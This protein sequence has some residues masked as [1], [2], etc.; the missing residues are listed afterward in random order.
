M[1]EN[2]NLKPEKVFY[3]FEEI[4]NIPRG[5]GNTKAVSDYCVNFAKERGLYVRQDELNNVVIKKSATDGNENKPG[6]IIQGHLDMVAEKDSDS[7]HDFMK[8]PIELIVDGDYITANKTTL[9]ADDG[10]AV[11]VALALLDDNTVKHPELEIIFTVDEETGMYGAMGLDMSDINGKYLLNLDSE[12]DGIITVGCAGGKSAAVKYDLELAEVAGLIYE[13]KISGLKGGHSGVEI[14]KERANANILMGRILKY[15]NDR[16]A[17]RLVSINGGAKDNVITKESTARFI[18][19]T[20]EDVEAKAAKMTE[21]LREVAAIIKNEFVISDKDISIN[22]S[23]GEYGIFYSASRKATNDILAFINAVPF[24]PQYRVPGM[25]GLVETSL[26]MGVVNTDKGMLS[27]SMSI[28]SSVKSRKD[29]MA[30]KIEIL[31]GLTGAEFSTG[32]EYPEWSYKADSPL[33]KLLCKVYKKMFNDELK[34][35]V[36]HAGL[37]CGYVLEKKPDLDVVSFGPQMYDIHTTDERVSISSV[38]K[39]YDFVK[40]ILEEICD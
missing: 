7:T 27:I 29:L 23:D 12:D 5:S 8:D 31:A 30:E 36:I 17:I 22:L 1:L 20:H 28:R 6:V 40:G 13:L 15:I 14:H 37:E 2:Y 26:N 4:S 9:G 38:A 25:N 33:Q 21:I 32:G 16:I 3:Y 39:L 18:L 11:A 10:I 34:I 35:D 19:H 24:G